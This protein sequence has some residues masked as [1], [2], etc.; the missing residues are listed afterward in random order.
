[1]TNRH[2]VLVVVL[3]LV[4]C[5]IYLLYW[6]VTTKIEMTKA[7][8]AIP[9]AWLLII[10][11]ANIYWIWR[12]SQGVEQVTKGQLT[13]VSAFLLLWLVGPI[14]AAISQSYFNKAAA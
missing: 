12:W 7:G 14:G 3:S 11:F 8:A 10:P 1:M 13:A 9:T 6:L 4:T 5:G 2:P